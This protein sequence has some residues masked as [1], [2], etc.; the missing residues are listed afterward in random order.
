MSNSGEDSGTSPIFIILL[1]CCC[2]LLVSSAV[3]AGLYFTNTI[4]DWSDKPENKKFLGTSCP[5][6]SSPATSSPD[7]SS[8]PAVTQ[9][10]LRAEATAIQASEI[11]IGQSTF[12]MAVQPPT[13]GPVNYTMSMDLKVTGAVPPS[14]RCI[15]GSTGGVDWNSGANKPAANTRRPLVI[16]TGADAAPANRICVNHSNAA[17]GFQG[18]CTTFTATSGTYFNLTFTCDSTAKKVITYINGVKD[19]EF[20]GTDFAWSSPAGTWVWNNSTYGKPTPIMVKNAYWFTRPLTATEVAT[21]AAPASG[22]SN[23]MPE[24][25]DESSWSVVAF[26]NSGD[27]ASC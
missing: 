16:L 20:T 3:Y 8:P 21:L 5:D 6:T 2:L 26:E 17:D 23:Y 22:T 11:D 7:T 24:P 13:T 25:N 10:S 15:L 4:C 9:A 1:V 12:P 19:N 18:N 27:L 14:W